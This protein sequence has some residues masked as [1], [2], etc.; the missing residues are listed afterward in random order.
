MQL[1]YYPGESLLQQYQ[2]PIIIQP[3]S[4]S[5]NSI[6]TDCQQVRMR[7]PQD[8]LDT[9]SR[10]QRSLEAITTARLQSEEA[11]LEAEKAYNEAQDVE[12][13]ASALDQV[14]AWIMG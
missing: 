14:T 1:Y 11:W 4:Y 9:Q 13:L 10:I 7:S 8:F 12:K 3:I 6:A 2:S 5:S